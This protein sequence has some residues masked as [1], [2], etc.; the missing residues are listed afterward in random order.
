MR[1]PLRRAGLL[2]QVEPPQP[3]R[4]LR[5]LPEADDWLDADVLAVGLSVTSFE[6]LDDGPD[7]DH[8]D[9]APED[10]TRVRGVVSIDPRATTTNTG[11]S[12]R[13]SVSS[14]AQQPTLPRTGLPQ[15]GVP[16]ARD[17]ATVAG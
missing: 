1:S 6:V 7:A 5:K 3:T 17:E 4:T 9:D 12:V 15:A 14:W 2:P 16:Q 11:S 8:P 10:A 13:A